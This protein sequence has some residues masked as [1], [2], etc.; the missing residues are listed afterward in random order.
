MQAPEPSRA[1]RY[2][3]LP[4]C[5][6]PPCPFVGRNPDLSSARLTQLAAR[7]FVDPFIGDREEKKLE[8]PKRAGFEFV[9]QGR[10]Q[11]QAEGQ[12]LRVGPRALLT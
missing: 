9:Q 1:A 5:R 4:F 12:R 11:R 3:P 6:T 8:R 7:S 2:G 10:L